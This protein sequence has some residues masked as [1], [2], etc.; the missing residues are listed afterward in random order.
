M[1]IVRAG[2]LNRAQAIIWTATMPCHAMTRCDAEA[3]RQPVNRLPLKFQ[4]TRTELLSEC[5][6]ACF[7]RLAPPSNPRG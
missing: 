6:K 4:K 7:A 1:S 3:E 5:F 2:S